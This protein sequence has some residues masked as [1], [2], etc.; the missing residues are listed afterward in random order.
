MNT[1]VYE[2][3]NTLTGKRYIGSAV[4]LPK[5]WVNH[6]RRLVAGDHHTRPLQASW[7]KHGA[8]VFVFRPL[9][10]CSKEN[11]LIY[12]QAAMDALNPEFNVRRIARSN[13]GVRYSDEARARMSAALQGNRCALGWKRTP[14]QRTKDAAGKLGKKR[15]DLLG[16]KHSP[17][18]IAKMSKPR[19]WTPEGLAKIAAATS[20]R[21]SDETRGRMSAAAKAA[22]ARRKGTIT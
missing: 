18:T 13:L 12:E 16:R 5:R 7:D 9:I 11:L 8:G 3:V 22:W 14:E 17:E 15:P 4:S 1:G 21:R 2:I 20:Y 19:N 6:R 10:L